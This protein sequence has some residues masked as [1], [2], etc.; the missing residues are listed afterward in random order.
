MFY[1]N[2]LIPCA[3]YSEAM[4][5]Q[6]YSK[7]LAGQFGNLLSRATGKALLPSRIIPTRKDIDIGDET[8]HHMLLEVAGIKSFFFFSLWLN[9]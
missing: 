4:I 9:Y 6:L 8:L 2:P 1:K 5:A 3:D 7:E